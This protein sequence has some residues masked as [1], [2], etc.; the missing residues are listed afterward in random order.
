MFYASRSDCAP[1]MS[2]RALYC[3]AI[4]VISA[5]GKIVPSRITAVEAADGR[6]AIR[7]TEKPSFTVFKLAEPSR[8]VIDLAGADVTK[9]ESFPEG[10]GARRPEGGNW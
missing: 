9:V 10:D 1:S 4:C 3:F 7:G 6:L 2:T 8:L 5:T